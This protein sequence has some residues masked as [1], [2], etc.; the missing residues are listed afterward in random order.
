MMVRQ[1]MGGFA[2]LEQ[3]EGRR[4]LSVSMIQSGSTLYITGT[5]ASDSVQIVDQHPGL[6]IT[7]SVDVDTNHD[8][9]FFSPGDKHR[10]F[11]GITDF[12]I[13]M[14][15]PGSALSIGLD[16]SY[17]GVNKSFVVRMGDGNDSFKFAT[18]PGQGLRRSHVTLDVSTGSGDDKVSLSLQDI[19]RSSSVTGTITTNG[20]NDSVQVSGSTAIR[21]SGVALTTNLGAGRDSYDEFVDLEGFRLYGVSSSWR[22]I[23]NGGGGNDRISQ[24]AANGTRSAAFEGLFSNDFLGGLGSD[25]ISVNMAT[26][27]LNGGTL[28]LNA[29]GGDGSDSV[30][31]SATAGPASTGG[32]IDIMAAGGAGNDVL[33]LTVNTDNTTNT[34][35]HRGAVLDGGDGSDIGTLLGTGRMRMINL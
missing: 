28:H 2:G 13:S 1:T 30:S 33:G 17:V 26:L 4:L 31:I 10:S 32:L 15:G 8:G 34:Y 18:A 16:S 22:T 3:L 35:T 7:A 5:T 29:D 14:S 11:T 12:N 23:V 25:A 27:S 6:Q 21:D 9:S 20:G 19:A 24:G